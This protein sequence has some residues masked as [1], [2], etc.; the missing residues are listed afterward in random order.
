MKIGISTCATILV[1][2]FAMTITLTTFATI[3]Q[4][5][6]GG[7]SRVKFLNYP[8]CV[9]LKNDSTRVVLGHHIGGRILAYENKGKNVLFVSEVESDWNPDKSEPLKLIS[10]GRF[11][12]GPECTQTRGDT[13]WAGEWKVKST[14]LRTAIMTSEKDPDSGFLVTREIKLAKDSSRV[15]ITQTVENQSDQTTKHGYWSRTL[16]VPGGIAVVP[17]TPSLSTFPNGYYMAQNKYVVDFNP[18]DEN[19]KR[20][21]DFLV[22]EAPPE[23]AKLG[24]D[25]QIGWVAYQTPEGQLFVKRFPVYPERKYA[26]ATGINLSIWY[27][28]PNRMPTIEIEPIGP[29][30]ILQPG[31]KA[32]Y[33]VD[34][35]LLE[36]PFPKYGKIDPDAIAKIVAEKCTL[37][38]E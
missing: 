20:V 18:D 1:T 25:S 19:V 5:N 9:E 6:D 35:W 29:M 4:T 32:S 14:G 3:A 30:E 22:V 27:P 38:S 21:G 10:A 23:R 31:E 7:N 17:I 11:D 24:F 34:W 36:N 16:A 28:K 26:E 13:L 15:T 33:S 8:D 37:D 2:T 12:V